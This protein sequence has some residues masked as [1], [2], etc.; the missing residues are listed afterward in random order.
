MFMSTETD[1]WTDVHEERQ[2]LLELLETLTSE[3]WDARSLCTEWQVRDVVGHMVS[4][5]HMTVAQVAWGLVTSGFRINRFIGKDARRRGSA[6][7]AELLTDFR[8]VLLARSH[9]PGLSSL[10]MLTDIVVHQMDIRCPLDLPRCVP[11][12]RMI[13]VASNLWSNGFFPG[14]KL[15]QDLRATATDAE[16]SAGDGIDIAGPIEALVL[17]LAGRFSALDQLHG[18]GLATLRLRAESF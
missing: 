6:P 12:G 5:T 18:D 8:S 14:P 15:F 11:D 13:P 10:S 3:Q 7:V 2:A 4:E 16:W 9:L 1:V 17:T